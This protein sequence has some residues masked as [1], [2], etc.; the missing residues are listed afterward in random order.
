MSAPKLSEDIR[1][2]IV[3][4]RIYQGMHNEIIKHLSA[5]P[6]RATRPPGSRS[7]GSLLGTLHRARAGDKEDGLHASEGMLLPLPTAP[8]PPLCAHNYSW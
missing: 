7:A 4:K 3:F 8:P 5:G 2:H 6:V 1:W